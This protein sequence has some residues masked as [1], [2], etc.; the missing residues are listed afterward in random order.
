MPSVSKEHRDLLDPS[1][2]G[3]GPGC[4]V[5]LH[6]GCAFHFSS[7]CC[8]GQRSAPSA[9][10]LAGCPAVSGTRSLSCSPTPRPELQGRRKALG[11]SVNHGQRSL[12]EGPERG[13]LPFACVLTL[14]AGTFKKRVLC[15]S[16]HAP[17]FLPPSQSH[18][19]LPPVGEPPPPCL[20]L[21]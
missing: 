11:A 12:T 21:I 17:I 6:R 2:C 9:N 8:P 5:D 3:R 18:T 19:V 7:P 14:L 10:A 1:V 13:T 20:L 15:V 4:A 16:V